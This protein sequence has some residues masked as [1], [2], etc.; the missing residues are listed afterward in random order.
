MKKSANTLS[1]AQTAG[2]LQVASERFSKNSSRHK[3]ISWDDVAD[4]LQANP[5]ALW[6]LNE[7]ETTGG[8]PDVIGIDERTGE[9]LICDCSGESPSGRRSVCYDHEG[10]ES[11]KEHRPANSAVEMA[12]EMGIELLSEDDY[13]RLQQLGRF[14]TK[15]SSWIRTPAPVRKLGGAFFGDWRYGMV[16]IYHNGAQSYYASRGFRGL[17]RL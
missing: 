14:D 3:G 8:E 15:T 9:L 12:A 11:R 5:G 16:F 13:R 1:S 6:S 2:L 4:R 7:M 17:L 10:L